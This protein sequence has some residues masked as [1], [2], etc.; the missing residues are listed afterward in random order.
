MILLFVVFGFAKTFVVVSVSDLAI[1]AGSETFFVGVLVI[2]MAI[3]VAVY[4]E[5]VVVV[6]VAAVAVVVVV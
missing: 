1:V 4:V 3:L 5:A 6:V 2:A